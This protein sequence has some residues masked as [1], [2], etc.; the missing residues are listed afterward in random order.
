MT[1]DELSAQLHE[2]LRQLR[3]VDKLKSNIEDD[4]MTLDVD[5]Y[6]FYIVPQ[7]VMVKTI[8]GKRPLPGFAMSIVIHK[9][10][11]DRDEPPCD[12]EKEL[13]EFRSVGEVAEKIA[14]MIV[15]DDLDNILTN[16]GEAQMDAASEEYHASES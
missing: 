7:E 13:G 14:H 3:F 5:G 16:M 9:E 11:F 10:S 2:V 4:C 12:D 15:T 1:L 8:A 6:E